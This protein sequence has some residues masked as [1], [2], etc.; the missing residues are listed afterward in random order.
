VV[1]RGRYDDSGVEL[2]VQAASLAPFPHSPFSVEDV[3]QI[4]NVTVRLADERHQ[5][6]APPLQGVLQALVAADGNPFEVGRNTAMGNLMSAE[7]G[8]VVGSSPAARWNR[9]ITLFQ[10]GDNEKSLAEANDAIALDAR[11][12]FFYLARS[13]VRQ[14]MGQFDAALEDVRTAQRLGPERWVLPLWSLGSD[15]FFLHNDPDKALPF[16]DQLVELRPT[17]WF[18]YLMRGGMYYLQGR[19]DLAGADIDRAIDLGPDVNFPYFYAIGIALRQ[20]RFADAQALVNTVLREF[21]DPIFGERIISGA[22]GGSASRNFAAPALKAFGNLT[23]RQW[24]EAVASA[25]EALATGAQLSDLY[26][27]QGFAYCNLR[28]YEKAEAAYTQ[29]IEIDPDFTLLYALRAEVRQKQQNLMGALADG[30]KVLES[31]QAELYQPFMAAS[32]AGRV[33]CENFFD[34]DLAALLEEFKL[35]VTP[36]PQP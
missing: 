7:S 33:N 30:A 17:D 28:D 36:T 35:E 1:I 22:W 12:P 3:E 16:Y 20:G 2:E 15:A 4:A 19:Y 6:V 31:D 11:N 18:S 23:L 26:F 21:P 13:L 27:M 29:G 32:Q 34:V 24:S 8:E 9:I 25:D 5:S 14:K 10:R